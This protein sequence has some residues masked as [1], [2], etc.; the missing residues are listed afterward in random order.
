M[1]YIQKGSNTFLEG[2]ENNMFKWYRHAL[3]KG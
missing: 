2:M 1:N 3:H